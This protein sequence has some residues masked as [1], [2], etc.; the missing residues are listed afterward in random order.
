M[1][2]NNIERAIEA[3]QERMRFRETET[4]KVIGEL[5]HDTGNATS[6]AGANIKLLKS[7]IEKNELS[8]EELIKRLGYL[9]DSLKKVDEIVD[10]TYNYFKEKHEKF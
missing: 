5:Y 2:D 4:G 9:Q 3:N 7:Y 6:S 1:E 8:H 10:V